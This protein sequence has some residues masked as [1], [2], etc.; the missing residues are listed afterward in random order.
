MTIEQQQDIADRTLR[1]IALQ[2][3]STTKRDF[4]VIQIVLDQ[5]GRVSSSLS[6]ASPQGAMEPAQATSASEAS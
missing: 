1:K 2:Y 4:R 3:G 5:N 6:E